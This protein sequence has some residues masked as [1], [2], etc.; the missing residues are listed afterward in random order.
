MSINLHKGLLGMVK[1]IL[2][3]LGKTSFDHESLKK[4][5]NCL[6]GGSQKRSI[7]EL[8]KFRGGEIELEVT[9]NSRVGTANRLL[10]NVSD[11]FSIRYEKKT[12]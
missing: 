3:P 1:I 11:E 6:P 4:V 7:E 12:D 5:S 2:T 8:G 10:D 9:E